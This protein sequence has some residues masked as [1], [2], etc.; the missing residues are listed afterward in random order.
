MFLSSS[1]RNVFLSAPMARF[2]VSTIRACLYCWCAIHN[3]NHY[4]NTGQ[5]LDKCA[6]RI[7]SVLTYKPYQCE[8]C[9]SLLSGGSSF[10]GRKAGRDEGCCDKQIARHKHVRSSHLSQ[11]LKE[12]CSIHVFSFT[13]HC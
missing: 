3:C 10:R 1:S 8:H 13:I 7:H 11:P 6:C 9:A 5:S 2:P 4:V 12:L